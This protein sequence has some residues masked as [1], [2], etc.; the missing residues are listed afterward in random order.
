MRTV[1]EQLIQRGRL[2]GKA[3]GKAE[4]LFAVLSAREHGR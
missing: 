4:A 1:A 3:E 2:E